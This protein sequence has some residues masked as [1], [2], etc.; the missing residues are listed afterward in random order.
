MAHGLAPWGRR[1]RLAFGPA[2]KR[3][4]VVWTE[5]W[6][7]P[8]EHLAAVEA[9]V[10]RQGAR[11]SRGGD[12]DRWDLR[13]RGGG[14]GSVRLRLAVEEHGHGRQQLLY[15]LEPRVSRTGALATT[16]TAALA[17]VA[18]ADDGTIAGLVLAAAALCALLAMVGEVTAALN[19][20]LSAIDGASQRDEAPAAA[21]HGGDPLG[22][23]RRKVPMRRRMQLLRYLRPHLR[24]VGLVALS[25]V[26]ASALTLAQPWPMKLLLD[27]VIGDRPA[28]GFL[29]RIASVLPGEGQHAL[30]ALVVAGSVLIFFVGYL[31]EMLS[32]NWGVINRGAGKTVWFEVPRAG[33]QAAS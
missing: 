19:C 32:S 20:G 4:R 24:D 7:A 8:E 5:E 18:F 10:R 31:V 17:T 15:A 22:G 13:I 25:L 29:N 14:I 27:N 23:P 11:V 26:G 3:R 16:A 33:A 6:R 30:L 21:E 12:Y 28:P 9:G 1:A 2:H